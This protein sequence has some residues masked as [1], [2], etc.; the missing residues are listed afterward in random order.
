[1]LKYAPLIPFYPLIQMIRVQSEYGMISSKKWPLLIIWLVKLIALEPLRWL[2]AIVMALLPEK[3]A[4]PIFIIGYYR[5]GTTYLQELLSSDKNRRTLT[6]FQSVLPEVSLCFDWLFI[7]V[8][9]AVTAV[10]RIKNKYH[11]IPFS[12]RF[13]GEEDVAIN[14]MMALHDYNRIYQYPSHHKI[15]TERYLK[16]Q[17]QADAAKWLAN[18]MY[19]IKKLTYRYGHKQLILK[20]PPNMGRIKL[21][22]EAFPGAKFIFIHRDP[23]ES[24]PSAKRLWKLNRAFAFR[25]YS[26]SD[27]ENILVTQYQ[28]LYELFK[29]QSGYTV[30]TSISFDKLITDPLGTLEFIYNKLGLGEWEKA[31]PG[32]N[33]IRAKRK[34]DPGIK[35][36]QKVPLFLR[37]AGSIQ[38]IRKELGYGC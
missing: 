22:R 3:K 28:C 6:L 7:P 26:E 36:F 13:P 29:A 23:F 18:Y 16:F 27:V 12:W 20:S 9:S 5:S 30:C 32:I 34:K 11:D 8:L 21:L 38:T 15:I 35:P 10:F 24:I 1:M 37:E 33:S 4:Q 2:E 17:N 19:L 14:A 31:I 25:E